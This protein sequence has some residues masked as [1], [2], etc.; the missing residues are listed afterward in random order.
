MTKRDEILQLSDDF[1]NIRGSFRIFGLIDIGTQASL[2][3]LGTGR[4][5]FLD[6]YTLRGEVRDEILKL[7]D[8]GAAVDAIINLHPFHTVHCE[9]MHSDFPD[10]KLYGTA[11]H[12][13]L[14]PRLHWQAALTESEALHE[15]FAADLAFSVPRG[16]ELVTDNDNVHFSSVL[17]YHA[18]SRSIHVDDTLMY[19][20]LFGLGG[21]VGFHPTL[22]QA[23][24]KRSGA[25]GDF[26]HWA[27][28]LAENWG[29]ARHL[30]AAHAGIYTTP[31]LGDGLMR[32]QILAALDRV[33]RKLAAHEKRYG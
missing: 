23:M 19:L 28:K 3:Q 2:V 15:L 14:L 25:A 11:R 29:D 16:V 18:A 21:K 20:R 6:S 7:T 22:S 30:C 13:E 24:E 5:V 9:Q 27:R 8:D 31:G 32:E 10:A 26:R 1:W 4:F 12:A 17:A 33:S